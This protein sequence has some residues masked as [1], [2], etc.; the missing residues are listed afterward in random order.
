MTRKPRH[1]FKDEEKLTKFVVGRTTLK[2]QQVVLEKE[3]KQGHESTWPEK[4]IRNYSQR[5]KSYKYM[6]P[7]AENDEAH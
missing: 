1:S 7:M 6:F 5:T 3:N 4:W 2:K